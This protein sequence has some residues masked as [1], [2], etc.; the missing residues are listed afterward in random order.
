[1]R[2]FYRGDGVT[3]KLLKENGVKVISE[4]EL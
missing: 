3:A 4:E 2:R 1:M